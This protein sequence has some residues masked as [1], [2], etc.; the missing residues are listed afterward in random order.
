MYSRVVIESDIG[1][2]VNGARE[3]QRVVFCSVLNTNEL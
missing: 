1:F 3:M 2:G